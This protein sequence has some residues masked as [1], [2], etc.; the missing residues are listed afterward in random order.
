[1]QNKNNIEKDTFGEMMRN[2]LENVQAP[3][4][5]GLWAEIEQRMH[6]KR[7]VIPFWLWST[8]GGIAAVAFIVLTLRPF[9]NFTP[10]NKELIETI[11]QNNDIQPDVT[12]KLEI[13]Y[14]QNKQTA[15]IEKSTKNTAAIY[16]NKNHAI[17]N[18]TI[19][20]PE[21]EK[22]LSENK[23][24]IE[25]EDSKFEKEKDLAVNSKEDNGTE[26][27]E[28][29]EESD[30]TEVLTEKTE[31][32]KYEQLKDYQLDG[33]REYVKPKRISEKPMLAASFGTGDGAEFGSLKSFDAAPVYQSIV[34][35]ETKY[36]R[37][38]AAADFTTTTYLPPVSFG[39]KISKEFAKNWSLESG[40]VYTYMSS[41]YKDALFQNV[42]S[43]LNLHYLGIPVNLICNIT[44]NKKWNIYISGGGMIEKGLR[45]IY[46]QRSYVGNY[47]YTTVAKTKIEGI[48]LS[49]SSATGISYLI[50]RDIALYAEPSITYYFKNNQPMSARTDQPLVVGFNAG[51]KFRL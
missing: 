23:N 15:T 43:D 36:S 19:T 2:R 12:E 1:M 45:S 3:V 33:E 9:G 16:S 20:T 42:K 21:A 17:L 44:H 34:N 5:E 41:I 32:K 35:A 31:I 37:I 27:I 48:Q 14:S 26:I 24:P 13:S 28:M 25:K 50:Y 49:V 30:K 8:L 10:N 4:D 46:N 7:R 11:S 39:L 22:M 38:M 51:L 40:L 6:K 29:K 18:K 47:E